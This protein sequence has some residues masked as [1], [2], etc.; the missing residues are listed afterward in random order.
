MKTLLLTLVVVTIVCL[1]LGYTR[2]CFNQQ[3]WRPETT[4]TCPDGE[5]TCYKKVFMTPFR[6]PIERGCGC[7]KE[8]RSFRLMCC[9]KD[10]CNN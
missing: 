5:N 8:R 2:I 6:I 3:S 7:P 10:K 9:Q 1:D 4:T